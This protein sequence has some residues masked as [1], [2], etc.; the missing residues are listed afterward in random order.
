[1]QRVPDKNKNKIKICKLK[2][3]AI[4]VYW[5]DWLEFMVASMN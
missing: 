1:M 2:P 4:I 5:I 3:N